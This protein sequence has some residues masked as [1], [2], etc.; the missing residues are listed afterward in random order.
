M[1]PIYATFYF[2]CADDTRQIRNDF[3]SLVLMNRTNVE[4]H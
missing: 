4:T 3:I 2:S 1:I